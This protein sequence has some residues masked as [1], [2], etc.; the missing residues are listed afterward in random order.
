[1]NTRQRCAKP[2]QARADFTAIADAS[3][4]SRLNSHIPTQKDLAGPIKGHN[5]NQQSPFD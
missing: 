1:M 2:D 3:I 5:P 4:S